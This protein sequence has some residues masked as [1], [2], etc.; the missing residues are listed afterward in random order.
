MN[1]QKIKLEVSENG[2]KIDFID[3]IENLTEDGKKRLLELFV[4]SEIL[5]SIERQLKGKTD[6]WGWDTSGWRD[7]SRLR[8]DILKIQGLEPEF[9]KDLESKIKSLQNDVDNYK[10]YYDWYFKIYHHNINYLNSQDES[11]MQY[12]ERLVGK[13]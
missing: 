13:P 2:I 11:L 4:Y 9:K 6:L 8:E 3:I 7:S 10:K 1:T 12:V 5:D